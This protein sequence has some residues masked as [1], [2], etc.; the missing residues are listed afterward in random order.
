MLKQINGQV[1]KAWWYSVEHVC[2]M[3]EINKITDGATAQRYNR[4]GC[5]DS[6]IEESMQKAGM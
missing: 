6:R 2:V 4:G 5:S 1:R 3:K